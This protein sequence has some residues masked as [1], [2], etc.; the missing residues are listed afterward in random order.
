M[1]VVKIERIKNT[2]FCT[3]D[4]GKKCHYDIVS[5]ETIGFSGRPLKGMSNI[6]AP[7]TAIRED[8]PQKEFID[9][10]ISLNLLSWDNLRNLDISTINTA[11]RCATLMETKANWKKALKNLREK[12]NRE[13]L[14]FPSLVEYLFERQLKEKIKV[15][16]FHNVSFDRL[17][18]ASWN[19]NKLERC[20]SYGWSAK[21]LTKWM[22][23]IDEQFKEINYY[24][25]LLTGRDYSST[26]IKDAFRENLDYLN[27]M[28]NMKNDYPELTYDTKK[29][30]KDNC[31]QWE[32]DIE[33]LKN[34]E[35]SKKFAKMQTERDYAFTSGEYSITI[36][37][38]Y[39]DCQKISDTFHNCVAHYYWH[40]YLIT[41]ERLVVIIN[42]NNVPIICCGIDRDTLN[43]VDYLKPNNYRV[44]DETDLAFE[45]EYQN[46]LKSLL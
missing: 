17:L 9:R 41:G 10:L 16:E 1:T 29:T 40:N 13:T 30:I 35:A 46:Y 12:E 26:D 43:I 22:M 18:N 37:T 11:Q 23:Q 2:Y 42:K 44:N 3:N 34:R 21:A 14:S 45:K 6:L 28:I 38:D 39:A 4:K 36:P 32:Q 8:T 19:L 7:F 25:R 20:F 27:A 31:Y 5:R 33:A 24:H 15:P